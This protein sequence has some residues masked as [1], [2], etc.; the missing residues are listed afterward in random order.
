MANSKI[1]HATVALACTVSLLQVRVGE[2]H[3]ER[4]DK[5]EADY[6]IA[7]I[8]YHSEYNKDPSKDFENDIALIF[9]KEP[10]GF[11]GPYAGKIWC[12]YHQGPQEEKPSILTFDC[13]KLRRRSSEGNICVSTGVKVKNWNDW[14]W[15]IKLKYSLRCFMIDIFLHNLHSNMKK[16]Q[17]KQRLMK[18]I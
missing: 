6:E 13:K 4:D 9:L 11:S 1:W 17:M 10:V 2:W 15:M 8:R 18:K 3:L 12:R 14:N 16:N 7:D 5:T